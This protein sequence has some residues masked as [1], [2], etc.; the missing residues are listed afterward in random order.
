MTD[1]AQLRI[2]LSETPILPVMAIRDLGEGLKDIDGL[3]AAGATVIEIL[4]RT[5]EAPA[6]LKAAKVRHPHCLFGAGTMLAANHV[7]LALDSGADFTVSPGLTAAL[8]ALVAQSGLP[9]IPGVQTASETM[10]ACEYGYELMKY[11]PSQ[12]SNGPE[13][14]ADYAN[15]F[16]GVGF[17]T[18]G[19]ID[20]P[21][22]P[23]YG[24]VRNIVAVGG[25]WMLPSRLPPGA[26]G[27]RQ[28]A[29]IF[30]AARAAA[31]G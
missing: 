30:K 17:V 2:R 4:F 12:A 28:Q 11:Y 23:A 19:G 29:E 31:G 13:V 25:S 21:L 7:R 5:P 3:V 27:L 6:A 24:A 8:Q 20:I 1:I 22:L 26:P 18:T 9:H 15:I 10:Q 16:E 14:L